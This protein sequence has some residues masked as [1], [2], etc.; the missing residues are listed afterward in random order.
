[1][2][3]MPIFSNFIKLISNLMLSFYGQN[4][5]HSLVTFCF[6]IPLVVPYK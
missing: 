3:D 5:D 2:A 1:M 4:D 6:S